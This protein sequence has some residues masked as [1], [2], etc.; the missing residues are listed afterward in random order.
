M[1]FD[2]LY[3]IIMPGKFFLVHS[4]LE[5]YGKIW[6]NFPHSTKLIKSICDYANNFRNM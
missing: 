3:W 1:T 4:H 2:M 5:K 6:K